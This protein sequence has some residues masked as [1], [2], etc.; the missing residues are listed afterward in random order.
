MRTASDVTVTVT[1]SSEALK[2]PR[3]DLP[4]PGVQWGGGGVDSPGQAQPTL[5]GHKWPLGFQQ[6]RPGGGERLAPMA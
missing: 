5:E 6:S 2:V 1:V 3:K 4:W